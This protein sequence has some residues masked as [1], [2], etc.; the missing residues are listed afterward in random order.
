[1]A[2]PTD[3][4]YVVN[5]DIEN[6]F[7][8]LSALPSLPVL[9]MDALQQLEGH[10][11]IASMTTLVDKIGHDPALVARL[12]R[13]ANSSFYGMSREIASLREAIVVLGFNRVRELLISIC[14]SQALT[15]HHNPFDYK[16][17]WHHSMAVADCSRQLASLIGINPDIAFTAGLLHDI[18][19]LVIVF[20]FPVFI[21]TDTALHA[22]IPINMTENER[23]F[24][25][26]DHAEIGGKAALYW[27]FPV[28]I[29][30]AIEQHE[31]API[32]STPKSLGLLLYAVNLLMTEIMSWDDAD[33][34]NREENLRVALE[35]LDIPMGQAR[36]CADAGRQFADRIVAVL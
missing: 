25:C 14:F 13:I 30:E 35:I 23:Q 32:S 15:A 2:T 1:M 7:A 21:A 29:Q 20:L 12:L 8:C 19:Q 26:S 36:L 11:N 33:I 5:A 16:G 24:L 17:F 34:Q 9:L 10:H 28:A 22:E 27:N 31:T 4:S 18:G 3:N 6:K